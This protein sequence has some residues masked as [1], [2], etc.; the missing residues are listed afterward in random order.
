MKSKAHIEAAVT[1]IEQAIAS[2]VGLQPSGCGQT[3]SKQSNNKKNNPMRNQIV[4]ANPRRS[5]WPAC[6]CIQSVSVAIALAAVLLILGS[7]NLADAQNGLPV[8]DITADGAYLSVSDGSVLAI[9]AQ[10]IPYWTGQFTDPTVAATYSYQMVGQADPRQ[11]NGTT[12]IQVDL[13]PINFVF[14]GSGGYALNGSDKVASVLASPI[15]TSSDFSTTAISTGGPGA[16]SAGNANVQYLDAV[17][18]SEFNQAGID[19]HLILNPTVWPAVT[20]TVPA[21][22]GGAFVNSRGIPYGNV[23]YNWFQAQLWQTIK[24]LNLDPTQLPVFVGR[25]IRLVAKGSIVLGFHGSGCPANGLGTINGNG[26]QS[27]YTWIWATYFTPG[28]PLVGN[29]GIL[30]PDG[31]PGKYF[32]RDVESLSH[33]VGEW[34]N[35]PFGNN[36]VTSFLFP[37]LNTGYNGCGSTLDVGDPVQEIGFTMPGNSFDTNQY[38]DGYFHFEDKAFLPWFARENPNVTSQPVQG[39]STG[40]YTLMGNLNPYSYFQ[41]LAVNCQ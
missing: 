12:T 37:P 22:Q 19:Y 23:D 21:G 35:D 31:T 38:A 18:R 2:G 10:T 33:E 30:N 8:Q 11:F 32:V 26:V 14:A 20:F 7:R 28:L 27:I 1:T 34:A 6:S 40:R 16:L 9:G 13:I 5:F 25:A 24:T 15:F 29:L 36:P 3:K 4:S 17:M 41:A 39:G